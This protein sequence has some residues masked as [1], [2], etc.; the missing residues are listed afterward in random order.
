MEAKAV[1]LF[2]NKLAVP[3]PLLAPIYR[4]LF[5]NPPLAEVPLTIDEPFL[6]NFCVEL[7][8]VAPH[9]NP[10]EFVEEIDVA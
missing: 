8:F 5:A 6:Y 3:P 7:P 10:R 1:C 9:Q 4:L 2:E